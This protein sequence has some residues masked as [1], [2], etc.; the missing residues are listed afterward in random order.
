MAITDFTNCGYYFRSLADEAFRCVVRCGLPTRPFALMT[1]YAQI[2]ERKYCRPH[3]RPFRLRFARVAVSSLLACY[4]LGPPASAAQYSCRREPL[5]RPFGMAAA[6]RGLPVRLD[7]APQR[8]A[9]FA[10]TRASRRAR[11]SSIGSRSRARGLSLIFYRPPPRRFC[12]A[13]SSFSRECWTACVPS[14]K[15]AV[16]RALHRYPTRMSHLM[17]RFCRGVLEQ[18]HQ[19]TMIVRRA[20]TKPYR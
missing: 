15:L 14:S 20:K 6:R 17:H 9:A 10:I 4:S 8:G 7:R 11:T 18:S 19:R 13:H 16:S 5:H 12:E 2:T 1:Q 3:A